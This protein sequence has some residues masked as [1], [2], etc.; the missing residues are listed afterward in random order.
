MNRATNLQPNL[1]PKP[2]I[3]AG[4]NLDEIRVLITDAHAER[5]IVADVVQVHVIKSDGFRIIAGRSGGE[6]DGVVDFGFGGVVVA[7]DAD[8]AR[9]DGSEERREEGEG[10]LHCECCRGGNCA[11]VCWMMDVDGEVD[12]RTLYLVRQHSLRT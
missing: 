5:E 8:V 9:L 7:G 10:G 6:D 3:W 4:R 11:C 1:A 2:T 12:G